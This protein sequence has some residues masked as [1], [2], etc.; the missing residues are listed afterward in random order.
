M[1]DEHMS[2]REM[3]AVLREW[4]QETPTG[5]PDR[6]RVVSGVVGQLASRRPRRR[7]SLPLIRRAERPSSDDRT[8][9]L[10]PSPT[11]AMD[12]QTPTVTWRT[13]SM[14]S[15]AKVVAAGA[16]IF[17]LGGAF[18][19]AQPGDQQGQVVPGAETVELGEPVEFTASFGQALSRQGLPATCDVIGGV[20]HCRDAR[21][22]IQLLEVSDARLDGELTISF[23]QIQYP[24][25]P[26]FVT[27]TYRIF[28]EDG[29]WQ[30]SVSTARPGEDGSVSV[31]LV[32]ERA[33][34]G[35]YAWMD[36]SDWNAIK[37]VIYPSA[38]LEATDLS[39]AA[40]E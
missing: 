26:W 7:W 28:N 40:A 32:G 13:Q 37:G 36:V 10:Q 2:D 19:V 6:S 22:P 17:A 39:P 11:P 30:G 8:T 23:N 3:E 20:N 29:A 25:H 18:L 35:L 31:V 4:T 24:D 27:T 14:F 21:P 34:D 16:L 15:P 1:N 5:Q 9:G 33:Y 38:P 12:S